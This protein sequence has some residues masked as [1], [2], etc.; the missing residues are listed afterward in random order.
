MKITIEGHK[1]QDRAYSLLNQESLRKKLTHHKFYQMITS[2]Q[3]V[4][5]IL[6]QENNKS[7][8]KSLNQQLTTKILTP[9]GL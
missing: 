5:P 7:H 3:I 9:L 6:S 8:R 1:L 2:P 4:R